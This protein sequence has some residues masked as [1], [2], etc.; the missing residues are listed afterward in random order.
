MLQVVRYVSSFPNVRA[1][2]DMVFDNFGPNMIIGSLRIMV[3]E[4]MTARD[5]DELSRQITKGL[6]QK[7][8]LRLTVGIYTESVA[9]EYKPMKRELESIA[10]ETHGVLDV[11]AFS[12]DDTDMTCYF[13]IVV[14]LSADPEATT[15]SV[16]KQ[17]KRRYPAFTFSVQTDT[18]F[19]E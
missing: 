1:V 2:H 11:H 4:D 17:M 3:P 19:S 9:E 7:F 13:D 18:D 16:I 8:G 10:R 6:W 12:V 14:E 15:Q 5:I